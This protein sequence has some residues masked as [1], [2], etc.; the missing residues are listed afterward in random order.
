MLREK[1][2]LQEADLE[3]GD[4]PGWFELQAVW[5]GDNLQLRLGTQ[6]WQ[7]RV[8]GGMPLK[9]QARGLD[10]LGGRNRARLATIAF[11]P[12]AGG[13]LDEVV[14]SLPPSK[15]GGS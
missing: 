4:T 12:V 1:D 10:I 15:G 14:M 5:Q 6:S 11:G 7:L 9:V 13:V 3:L 8:P 2:V